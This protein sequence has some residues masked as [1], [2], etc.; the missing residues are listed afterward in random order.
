MR[1]I[2][3]V[4]PPGVLFRVER[5]TPALRFSRIDEATAAL[6][7]AGNRF[8]VLGSGVLYAASTVQAA[9][10]E[11]AA[12][13]RVSVTL[14]ERLATAGASA[15]DLRRPSL[16]AAWRDARVIRSLRVRD[17]LPF[18]DIEDARTHVLLTEQASPLLTDLGVPLLDVPAERGRS[19]LLTRGLA[20]WAR[21]ATDDAGDPL[22]GGIRYLSKL[23]NDYECWAIFEG[24]HLEVREER[25]ITPTDADPLAVVDRHGILVD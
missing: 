7:G 18:V 23:S 17:S 12:H 21:S 15:S 2:P 14:L 3:V 1:F 9:L 13:F 8:D 6:D 25:R 22:Y 20:T 19:R 10:A 5:L 16:G 4:M 24:A 11:T